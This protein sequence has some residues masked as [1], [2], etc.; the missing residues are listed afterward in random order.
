MSEK[1]ERPQT[2]NLKPLGSGARTPEEERA[3]RV[4]GALAAAKARK[5][6]ADIRVAVEAVFNLNA[7]GRGKSLDVEKMKSV[8]DLE[9]AD[10]PLI[11]KLAYTQYL[12]AING[13]KEAR[14]WLCR[15]LGADE[16][17]ESDDHE[18]GVTITA[19]AH[20]VDS[21][22]GVRIHL[23]RGEKPRVPDDAE[24]NATQEKDQEE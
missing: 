16:P 2:S 18:S 10:A 24:A 12:L 8:E 22:G 5:R 7:N 20:A 4:K 19:D 3:I 1:K 21:M 11:A 9:S 17:D 13:D 23:I 15:M 14:D 6:N